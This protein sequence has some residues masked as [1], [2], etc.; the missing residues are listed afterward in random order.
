LTT[1]NL[2]RFSRE[3]VV[4][5]NA[6]AANSWT[7]PSHASIFTGLYPSKHGA[8]HTSDSLHG[9]AGQKQ[10]YLDWYKL[11]S[12]NFTKL[13]KEHQALAEILSAGGYRTA[14]IIGGIFCNSIF[15]LSR[16]FDYYDD[17]VPSFNIKFFLVYQVID[18]VFSLNDF[19]TQYGYLGKRIAADLN[20]SAF[21]W[22]EKNH[23]H[24]FFLFINYMDAHTPY[25]P[26]S[27]Y[28]RYFGKDSKNFIVS[29]YG[30]DNPSFITA[31]T[32][33]IQTVLYGS[34]QLTPEE[35]EH[36]VNLYDGGIHFIDYSL[37]TL[38][39]K[40]KNLKVYDNT[41]IIITSDHGE[42]F[43]EHNHMEHGRT[44]YEEVLRV[45]LIIKYPSAYHQRG[46]VEKRVSLVDL[47]PTILSFLGSPVPAGIDGEVLE[48]SN[49]P[50][51]AELMMGIAKKRDNRVRDLRAIYQGQEK[52]IW[53]SNGS[54]ELYNLKKDPQ[55]EENL[56]KKF[57]QRVEA[58]E[59][60]LRDWLAS[61]KPA[62]TERERVTINKTTEEKL[63]AL[64]YLK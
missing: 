28:E 50:V 27:Q 3:G 22:L 62:T 13:S 39:D 42:A 19:F 32:N 37:G 8:D 4:F 12:R 38:F 29:H 34:H 41:M 56:V 15:G 30:K 24:P 14:G 26:P 60:A 7:L 59:R 18:R 45:P 52:Y 23:E 46:V 11:L 47:M 49:H 1:P 57:P 44:L 35:R 2:D 55:E 58:M 9:E 31:E 20:N 64:G 5:K 43:G 51:I 21:K 53:A 17:E 10:E 40:L 16:G 48:N 33:L 36:I 61:V 6:Y 63:R 54:N 25:L